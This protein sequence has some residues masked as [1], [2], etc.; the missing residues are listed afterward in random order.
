MITTSKLLEDLLKYDDIEKIDTDIIDTIGWSTCL[1]QN[2]LEYLDIALKN[3]SYKNAMYIYKVYCEDTSA[4][5]TYMING[6]SDTD[7]LDIFYETH[8]KNYSTKY[9]HQAVKTNQTTLVDFLIE[10]Q[11]IY[12]TNIL[13]HV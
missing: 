1:A 3:G 9:F 13:F 5:I 6:I 12:P 4:M 7:A 10:K 11:T 2:Y 8:L